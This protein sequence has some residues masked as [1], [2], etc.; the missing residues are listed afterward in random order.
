MLSINLPWS[1]KTRMG[2]R[3]GQYHTVVLLEGDYFTFVHLSDWERRQLLGDLNSW[4]CAIELPYLSSKETIALFDFILGKVRYIDRQSA[5][6]GVS[7]YAEARN[8][9]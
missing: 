1:T 2:S 5:T 6:A 4:L 9:C 7:L 3:E 8:S